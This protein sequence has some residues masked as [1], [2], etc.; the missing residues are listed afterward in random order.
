MPENGGK[1]VVA[2]LMQFTALC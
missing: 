1:L 2:R